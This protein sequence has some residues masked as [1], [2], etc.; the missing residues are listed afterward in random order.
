[1]MSASRS[2]N[3]AKTAF[4]TLLLVAV[5]GLAGGC[6]KN[7]SDSPPPL[8]EP[9]PQE[10]GD[11]EIIQ[12]FRFTGASKSN[13]SS[14][15]QLSFSGM[16]WKED[17]SASLPFKPTSLYIDTKSLEVF[18]RPASLP[19]KKIGTIQC[20][21]ETPSCDD[22]TFTALASVVFADQ[23]LP[24]TVGSLPL[25]LGF[26][27]T[28][29]AM[30]LWDLTA[31]PAKLLSKVEGVQLTS[32]FAPKD[33]AYR[34]YALSPLDAGLSYTLLYLAPGK[35]P[36]YMSYQITPPSEGLLFDKCTQGVSGTSVTVRCSFINPANREIVSTLQA[37]TPAKVK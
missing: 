31:S 16:Y 25:T 5:Q 17:W 2:M 4:M 1:M 18:I 7:S 28:A 14:F 8:P 32:N 12:S 26:Q 27:K 30:E 19:L 20:N 34:L 10:T 24:T 29:L 36:Y 23:V 11:R 6:N 21:P 35:L 15:I 9:P 3:F 13:E 33:T 37:L 22:F